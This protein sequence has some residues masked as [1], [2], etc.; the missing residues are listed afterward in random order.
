MTQTRRAPFIAALLCAC[1]CPPKAPP[2]ETAPADLAAKVL[3]V[4]QPAADGPATGAWFTVSGWFDPAQVQAV[5][6]VGAPTD[7]FYAPTGHVGVATVPVLTR[8]DGRFFAPRVPLQDGTTTVRLVPLQRGGGALAPVTRTLTVSD[9]A[10]VP[11]TLVVDPPQPEPGQ[12]ARLRASSGERAALSWQWDFEGDGVFDAEASNA[13][14][15]W[16]SSGRYAVTAR[17]LT[18]SG[19]VSAWA[20]VTVGAVP[21]VVASTDAVARPG[22][23]FV[24]PRYSPLPLVRRDDGHFPPEAKATRYVVAIDGDAVQVLDDALKPLFR[25]PG[26]D[27][28]SAVAGDDQG[29][30]YVADTGHDRVVRFTATGVLDASFGTA[31]AFRGAGDVVLTR[32]IALALSERGAELVLESGKRVDCSAPRGA[33]ADWASVTCG[34]VVLAEQGSFRSTGMTVVKRAVNRPSTG[35]RSELAYFVAPPLLISAGVGDYQRVDEAVDTVD[36]AVGPVGIYRDFITV[37]SGGR[38]NQF[39]LG[40]RTASWYLGYAATCIAT[41]TDGRVFV[42]GPGRIEERTFEA[43]R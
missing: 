23:L 2:S 31:G 10:S 33:M 12:K 36:V 19:W 37:D 4:D 14:H 32:P 17:T 9:A 11:A 38:V 26:L 5:L 7:G 43:L 29:R 20:E 25:L 27:A 42:G 39:H 24:V 30:L 8:P 3:I 35:F 6:V 1:S 18:A 28:P 21:P 40:R 34:S 15:A 41:G 16:P 22:R 13:E